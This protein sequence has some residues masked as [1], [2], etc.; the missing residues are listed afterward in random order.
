MVSAAL[1]RWQAQD[2]L[3]RLGS[4][5]LAGASVLSLPAFLVMGADAVVMAAPSRRR[6]PPGSK[7]LWQGGATPRPA[8]CGPAST[9]SPTCGLSARPC[10]H[11]RCRPSRRCRVFYLR[12][13]AKGR[14][15]EEAISTRPA[16]LSEGGRRCLSCCAQPNLICLSFLF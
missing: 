10:A 7:L 12:G 11:G 9:R 2:V 5:L 8:A 6:P 4:T 14:G 3:M 13:W 16:L 1:R 15:C